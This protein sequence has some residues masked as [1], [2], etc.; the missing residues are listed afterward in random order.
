MGGCIGVV[1]VEDTLVCIMLIV[2]SLSRMS[3]YTEIDQ[4]RGAYSHKGLR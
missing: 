4:E 3:M 2:D 1:C